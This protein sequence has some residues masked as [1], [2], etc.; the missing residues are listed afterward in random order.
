MSNEERVSGFVL[1]NGKFG[2]INRKTH[3]RNTHI[4]TQIETEKRNI[5]SY[6]GEGVLC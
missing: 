3:L 1:R 2:Y 6:L 4:E 5:E